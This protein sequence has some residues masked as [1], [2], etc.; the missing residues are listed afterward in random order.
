[1]NPRFSKSIWQMV[2]GFV[3]LV[4]LTSTGSAVE[5]RAAG[6]VTRVS[7]DSNEMQANA[8]SYI[9]DISADGRFVAFDSEATNLILDDTNAV[10]Y[11]HLDV[12][13]RQVRLSAI[14]FLLHNVPVHDL[15]KQCRD[16]PF[17]PSYRWDD[18]IIHQNSQHDDAHRSGTLKIK[19]QALNPCGKN[20]HRCIPDDAICQIHVPEHKPDENGVDVKKGKCKM[21]LCQCCKPRL[22]GLN[23][24]VIK[25]FAAIE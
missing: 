9:G 19:R 2:I 7:V 3:L 17:E 4:S 1:M 24:G 8:M 16:E 14:G 18:I 5:I 25:A 11:T 10:S 6:V 20:D 22:F 12:Y 13:K 15:Q 21:I 23:G